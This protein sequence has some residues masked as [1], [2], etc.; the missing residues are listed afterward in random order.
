MPVP[1]GWVLPYSTEVTFNCVLSC[2]EEPLTVTLTPVVADW[3]TVAELPLTTAVELALGTEVGVGVGD[4]F[5][6]GV[7]VGAAV[8]AAVGAGVGVGV[9][10]G[11]VTVTDVAVVL[12]AAPALSVTWSLKFQLPVAVDD[13]VAK[14]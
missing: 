12:T 9:G 2:S 8:G 7:G 14:L 4:G 11:A 5:G 3:S 1:E 13:V 6:V 10:V